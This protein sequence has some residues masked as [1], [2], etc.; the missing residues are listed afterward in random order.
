VFV[1]MGAGEELVRGTAL[2]GPDLEVRSVTLVIR[3]GVIAA[4]E[5]EKE[6]DGP[7]ICPAFFNAHTHVGDTVA[8]DLPAGGSLEEL[9]TPPH[10]LKHRI[11]AATPPYRLIGGMRASISTMYA[12]GTGGFADFREGGVAGVEHLRAASEGFPGKV[13]I[14]GRGGGEQMADGL[15]VSSAR[16]IPD[17]DTVVAGAKASGKKVAFHAGERDA[18]DV[19][20]ALS[21]DPD[22]LVHCTHATPSQIRECADRDIPIAICARSNWRL[23]VTRSDLHPPLKRM[24]EY[25]CTLMLG[26]DNA[27]FVQPDMWREMGFVSGIYGLDP[28]KILV[29][30]MRGSGE[31][32]TPYFIGK[33][34]RARFFVIDPDSSNLRFSRDIFTT[35]VNRAGSNDIVKKVFYS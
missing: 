26:T 24:E 33:G 21:Y 30:A 18:L 8:M 5:E 15:G 27:M 13:F 23:G 35:L 19:E 17:L 29:A 28:K 10:G 11:L 3:D 22:L 2:L 25:G 1:L 6:V 14:F 7:W 16:D 34:C 31:F 4:V 12:S 32:D 9:V 20:A